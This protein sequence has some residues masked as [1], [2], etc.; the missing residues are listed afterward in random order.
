LL[1]PAL[2]S[3][4]TCSA[5]ETHMKIDFARTKREVR[6][7]LQKRLARF[8]QKHPGVS[9]NKLILWGYGFG[10]IVHVRLETSDDGAVF[11]DADYE[12]EENE[13]GSGV[14]FDEYWPD[15]YACKEG[16]PYEIALEN[17]KTVT[18][19]QSKEGNNAIDKPLFNLL[20]EVLMQTDLADLKKAGSLMLAV[21]MGSSD[22]EETWNYT[23][24]V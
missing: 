18:T 24:P 17:G 14:R 7:Y 5:R 12:Y 21:E 16:E 3:Y 8:G 13:Y 10:K 1:L 9:V 2:V 22:L 4:F 19:Y 20:K 15:F 6:E 11:G 23:G